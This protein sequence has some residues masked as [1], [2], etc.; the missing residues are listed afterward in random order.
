MVESIVNMEFENEMF[1][2]DDEDILNGF[3]FG[4]PM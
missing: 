4:F 2:E 1:I 3:D